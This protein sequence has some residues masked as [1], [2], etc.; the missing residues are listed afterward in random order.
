MKQTKTA[1]WNEANLTADY[2]VCDN[3]DLDT[4]YL[5][6]CSYYHLK[7]GKLPKILRKIE[8]DLNEPITQ[9]TKVIKAKSS[10]C[11]VTS[12]DCQKK[13]KN[14]CTELSSNGVSITNAILNTDNVHS[15][16]ENHGSFTL[17]SKYRK[18]IDLF[19]QFVGESRELAYI[20]ERYVHK[21]DANKYQFI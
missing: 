17:I 14:E 6:F 3:I 1:L 19:E 7:F 15:D 8:N 5:D 18:N 12:D 9:R 4:I 10:E 20:I 11:K 21:L 2:K 16:V 13:G